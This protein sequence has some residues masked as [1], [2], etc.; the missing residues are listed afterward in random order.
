[1]TRE[2]LFTIYGQAPVLIKEGQ[3][4]PGFDWT[5]RDVLR[6][7]NANQSTAMFF[8]DI[9]GASDKPPWL[10]P[11]I[12]TRKLGPLWNG[13][14]TWGLFNPGD[15]VPVHFKFQSPVPGLL[16][17]APGHRIEF[18]FA[19]DPYPVPGF[20][21]DSV[22]QTLDVH[23]DDIIAPTPS[24]VLREFAKFWD[25]KGPDYDIADWNETRFG[26]PSRVPFLGLHHFG[27]VTW[28][29]QDCNHHYDLIASALASWLRTGNRKSWDAASVMAWRHLQTGVRLG[30][31][32]R[33]NGF[34]LHEY[35]SCAASYTGDSGQPAESHAWD[36]GLA[37]FALMTQ[38][39]TAL[40]WATTR[41][42]WLAA[43][44]ATDL[45]LWQGY[46]GS[47]YLG[48][49]ARNCRVMMT[50]GFWP[51]SRDK[52]A[53]VTALVN[54]ALA[55]KGTLP[56]LPNGNTPGGFK[57]WFDACAWVELLRLMNHVGVVNPIVNAG[58]TWLLDNAVAPD[59]SPPY[60]VLQWN[61]TLA[62]SILDTKYPAT[63]A[64]WVLPLATLLRH[65][66][67]AVIKAKALTGFDL[68]Q[69]GMVTAGSAAVKLAGEFS[70]AF[71]AERVLA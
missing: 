10:A 11:Y 27:R 53:H 68:S 61:G 41:A 12:H 33:S 5:K 66:K 55:I 65:P 28:G 19:D 17:L 4:L 32:W 3:A 26:T 20:V 15:P 16:P 69:A 47:R 6:V 1:M 54:R 22:L 23:P 56:Y 44:P 60:E 2:A 31:I 67:A 35:E 37:A 13:L 63:I 71:N 49:Y 64:G 18:R 42:A 34:G 58:A 14:P 50:L 36:A 48:W 39:A 30:G 59:G 45:W 25:L 8:H 7:E 62:N 43:T 51:K 70:W 38:D 9:A 57:T 21:D 24:P 29:A 40:R 46:G 52:V